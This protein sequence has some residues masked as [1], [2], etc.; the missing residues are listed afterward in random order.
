[1]LDGKADM[2]EVGAVLVAMTAAA[3]VQSKSMAGIVVD[4]SRRASGDVVEGW[5]EWIDGKAAL[6]R[7]GK[8]AEHERAGK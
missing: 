2:G 5:K 4:D 8:I 6:V 1:M 3:G 7:V